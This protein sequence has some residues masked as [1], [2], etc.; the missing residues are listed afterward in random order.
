[1][2]TGINVYMAV[3]RHKRKQ[4]HMCLHIPK[5]TLHELAFEFPPLT[6]FIQLPTV[7]E[8][9]TITLLSLQC[10]FLPCNHTAQNMKCLL[11]DIL[12]FPTK[13]SNGLQPQVI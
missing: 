8:M 4:T 2:H 7:K 13:L 5:Q 3:H 1:M 9:V 6:G 11:T 10:F 12:P